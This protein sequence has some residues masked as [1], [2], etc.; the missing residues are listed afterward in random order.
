VHDPQLL[1]VERDGF[2]GS[3][4]TGLLSGT[5]V[6]DPADRRFTTGG[7]VV[8]E[9]QVRLYDG[10]QRVAG[11]RG[12][13]RP[14][15]NG[16]SLA[17]GY[18][19]DAEANGELFTDDGWMFMGDVVEIDD[20]GYLTVVGRTSDFIIRGGKNIS[21]AAVEEEVATHPRVRLC[22]AVAVPDDRLGERVGV[23]VELTAGELDLD[24]LAAHLRGRGVS[25][26]W[27]PEHLAVLEELP[28]SSGGKVAK[29]ELRSQVGRFVGQ[30]PG[31]S[32]AES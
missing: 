13:G 9:M 14:A 29:G 12:R 25:K 4:E 16:P 7:R 20:E 1:R 5:T 8:E 28:R 15:C 31:R 10:D 32:Q 27:W 18:W 22:A 19:D 24:D 30:P 26:E 21:A 11:D 3:N 23:F 6:H 17:L 2:Y